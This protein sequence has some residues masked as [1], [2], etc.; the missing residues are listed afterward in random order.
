MLHLAWIQPGVSSEQAQQIHIRN[1]NATLGTVTTRGDESQPA[2]NEPGYAPTLSSRIHM[3]RNPSKAALDGTLR[4]HRARYL[5]VQ[6][7]LLYYR[8]LDGDVGAAM[9]SADNAGATPVADSPD[10]ALIEQLLAEEDTAPRLFRLTESRRMRSRE[11]HYLDHPLFGMLVEAWPVEL[12]DAPEVTPEAALQGD[13]AGAADESGGGQ[14]LPL[15][16]ATTQSGS[17]G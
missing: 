3:A 16:P 10:T 8:P 2:F 13:G 11:L 17:G 15:L 9:P 12:P 14:P 7:D 6:A 1:D 4:V 5:H